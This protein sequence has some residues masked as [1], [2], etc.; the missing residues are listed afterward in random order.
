MTSPS[1]DRSGR[2][3]ERLAA[4]YLRLKGYHV[5]ARRY[6]CAAG[7]IDLIAEKGRLLVFAEVK[8]RRD[9]ALALQSVSARQKSRISKAAGAYLKQNPELAQA[10][11]RFDVIVFGRWTWP[12]QIEDAWR[13]DH[14]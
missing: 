4:F 6:V 3:A 10:D 12:R 9:R 1:N 7:E 5:R 8:L 14:F 13:P 11:I 2:R